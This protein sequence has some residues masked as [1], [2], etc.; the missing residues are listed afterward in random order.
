MTAHL[1]IPLDTRSQAVD[2][3]GDLSAGCSCLPPP[4]LHISAEGQHLCDHGSL[5]GT[6]YCQPLEAPFPLQ[7][8]TSVPRAST[9]AI[10]PASRD[11]AAQRSPIPRQSQQLCT[12]SS[13]Q[14]PSC[15]QPLGGASPSRTQHLC[16]G[17]GSNDISLHRIMMRCEAIV[18]WAVS[19]WQ[20]PWPQAA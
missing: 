16:C 13:L 18:V 20:A 7:R 4:A 2:C 11:P 15:F 12:H 17:P 14:G 1:L 5:Q 6:G 3:A 8:Y 19:A 9:S 10:T